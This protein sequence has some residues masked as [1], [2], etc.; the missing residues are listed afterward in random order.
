M[1]NL[2]YLIVPAALIAGICAVQTAQ[3][4]SLSYSKTGYAPAQA[5]SVVTF[6]YGGNAHVAAAQAAPTYYSKTGYAEAVPSYQPTY[7]PTVQ[8]AA[9]HASYEQQAAGYAPVM[10]DYGSGYA[11]QA[12]SILSYQGQVAAADQA[13]GYG[14]HVVM[15]QDTS[16]LPGYGV[17]GAAPSGYDAPAYTA[18]GFPAVYARPGSASYI[19]QTVSGGQ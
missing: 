16:G 5:G 13:T 19:L 1:R 15:V 4:Q 9:P 10:T 14:S 11:E 6:S 2:T 8:Y 7:A 18:D 17:P 3:A 12:Q